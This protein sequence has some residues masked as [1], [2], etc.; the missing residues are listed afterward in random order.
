MKS[1]KESWHNHQFWIWWNKYRQTSVTVKQSPMRLFTSAKLLKAFPAA[2]AEMQNAGTR[3]SHATFFLP[4]SLNFAFIQFRFSR[5]KEGSLHTW[6]LDDSN[7]G[8]R[9]A[10]GE[11]HRRRTDGP[12]RSIGETQNVI[13]ARVDIFYLARERAA[14]LLYGGLRNNC[15]GRLIKCFGRI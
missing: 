7:Y 9:V 14:L 8:P 3:S 10:R 11:Y 15:P 6:L 2:D 12:R 4:F 5:E 1:T 13:H